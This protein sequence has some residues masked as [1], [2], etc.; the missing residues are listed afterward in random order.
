MWSYCGVR[1]YFVQGNILSNGGVLADDGLNF[2][3]VKRAFVQS[4]RGS[5]ICKPVQVDM[6]ACLPALIPCSPIGALRS[7]LETPY[8]K[9]TRMI[10]KAECCKQTCGC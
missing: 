8:L 2:G 6:L 10:S 4:I 5:L 7:L 9:T 1:Q 3:L